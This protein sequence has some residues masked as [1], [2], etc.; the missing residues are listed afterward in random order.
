MMLF[1][2]CV[3]TPATSVCELSCGEATPITRNQVSFAFTYWPIG[4]ADP[5]RLDRAAAPSTQTGA[6]RVSSSSVEEAAL[7][8]HA[9]P[10]ICMIDRI[11]SVDRRRILLRL[12]ES[13]W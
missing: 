4:S 7:R 3:G 6:P 12:S 13:S 8:A 5:N 11:D 1:R 9:S 2:S 10:A